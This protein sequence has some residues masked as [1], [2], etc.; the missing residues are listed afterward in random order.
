MPRGQRDYGLYAPTE[1]TA[2]VS[3][4]GEVA[5]RLGSIVIY[6]RRG[7]VVDFD[8]FESPVL[9]W[10]AAN[11]AAGDY[12]RL[13]S[14][15]NRSGAQ[16]VKLHSRN[17]AGAYAGIVK[18]VQPLASESLGMEI[19][20]D[21]LQTDCC[22]VAMIEYIGSTRHHLAGIKLDFADNKLYVWDGNPDW[23]EAG[24]IPEMETEN[25]LFYTLK[26]VVD[27]T[28][29]MYKRVMLNLNE[30]DISNE[31]CYGNDEVGVSIMITEIRSEN[32]AA[33]GGDTWLDDWIFTQDEP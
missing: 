26:F 13:D 1:V 5:A 15:N 32:L 10:E 33:V 12:A 28:T 22:L 11:A 23:V 31:A 7:I 25:H 30:Y 29:D 21:H 24:D 16:A 3:D 8:N 4:M 19:S 9:N 6:D 18:N 20:F 27:F 14:T 17:V 2:S